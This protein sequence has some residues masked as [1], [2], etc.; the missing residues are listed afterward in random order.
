MKKLDFINSALILFLAI[1]CSTNDDTLIDPIIDVWKPI[2]EVGFASDGTPEAFENTLCEQTSRYTLTAEGHF[3]H[4]EFHDEIGALSKLK[5][6]G[7]EANDMV[8]ISLQIGQSANLKNLF[9][10]NNDLFSIPAEIG[11]LSSLKLIDSKNNPIYSIPSVIC[12]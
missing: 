1:S 2:K 11:N 10:N 12:D 6:L 5:T 3:T 7:I 9:L 8:S 4:S